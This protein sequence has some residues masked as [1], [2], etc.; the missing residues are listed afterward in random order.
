MTKA[1]LSPIININ[2][3]SAEE[4]VDMRRD[5]VAALTAAI[6][7]IKPLVP[8]GRDYP[9][10]LDQCDADRRIHFDRLAELTAIREAIYAEAITIQR[11][12]EA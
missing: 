11:A 10:Q 12:T 2:G 9:G 8:N 3:T 5:A 7:A 6:E 4:H 1:T